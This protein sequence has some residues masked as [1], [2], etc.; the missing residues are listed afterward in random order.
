MAKYQCKNPYEGAV[1]ISGL[2]ATDDVA[3]N[4]PVMGKVIGAPEFRGPFKGKVD[5]TKS[6]IQIVG[7]LKISE[8]GKVV[9]VNLGSFEGQEIDTDVEITAFKSVRTD[10]E[11]V[12][13]HEYVAMP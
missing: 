10:K 3:D 9:P 1:I 11:G 12:T 2:S 13:R 6:Y 5:K 4:T 7:K 8:T